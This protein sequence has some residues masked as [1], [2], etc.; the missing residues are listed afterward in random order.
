ML[1]WASSGA[2]LTKAKEQLVATMFLIVGL[3][4]AGKTTLAEALA[5]ERGAVRLTPDAWMIPLFGEPDAN[6]KRDVL[7]GRL[8]WVA[9]ETLKREAGHE[10]RARLRMLE[11]K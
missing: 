1:V 5:T 8:I 9:L 7:E 2:R 10:C 3:P 11:S 4:A 6:G